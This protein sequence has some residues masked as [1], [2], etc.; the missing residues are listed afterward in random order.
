MTQRLLWR[1]AA[2]ADLKQHRAW[3][4]S[5]EGAKPDRIV[6]RI[7]A[8]A[9]SLLLLGD[10][11]RPSVTF[12]VR[13]LSV[14]SAPYVIVYRPIHNGFEILAVFHTAQQRR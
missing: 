1:A 10:I 5:L 11:G 12:G 2:L 4:S 9:Q 7:R 8:A 3:L 13:E 14:R 6:L